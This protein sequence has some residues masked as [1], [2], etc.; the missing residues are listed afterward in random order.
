M[1]SRCVCVTKCDSNFE[2]I[3]LRFHSGN[4]Q[5]YISKPIVNFSAS[6]LP[7]LLC[8]L[9]VRQHRHV[10]AYDELV[11]LHMCHETMHHFVCCR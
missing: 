2:T 6:L 11:I 9:L 7:L 5:T 8:V 1:H 3:K 10:N 4:V